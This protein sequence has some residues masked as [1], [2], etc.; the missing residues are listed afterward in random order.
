MISSF[1]K[2]I[3]QPIKP[4]AKKIESAFYF[5]LAMGFSWSKWKK[6]CSLSGSEKYIYMQQVIYESQAKKSEYKYNSKE[7][8]D[9][10]LVVGSYTEH[11]NWSD[12]DLF[13]MKYV[14]D[15]YKDKIAL[16]FACGP[17]R[18]IIKYHDRFSRIDGVDISSNNIKNATH[19]IEKAG[20]LVPNLYVSSGNDLGKVE[21]DYYDF[22]FSTIA[23][24]H[25]CV[26]EIRFSILKSM[27]KAL[28]LGGRISIQMGYG[29]DPNYKLG[30]VG[31]YDNY[32]NALSTNS[33]HDCRVENPKQVEDDLYSI[34]FKNFEYW[35]RP[36]G[37]GDNHEKWIFFTAIKE[38]S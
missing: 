36:V 13:L 11:N 5:M 7:G 33:Q 3:P 26:H 14:D 10:E 32:Y 21:N 30:A 6:Y 18:N 28:K 27:Y 16:D 38:T 25:I 8:V 17:G 31:Y 2:I 22:I 4:V 19:N 15:N 34:G 24:Q 37:P 29:D 35:I 12:Y 9:S 23:M 1:K 20:L